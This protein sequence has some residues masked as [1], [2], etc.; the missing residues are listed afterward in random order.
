MVHSQRHLAKA[1]IFAAILALSSA[2]WGCA[3]S[4]PDIPYAELQ[5]RYA[6]PASRFL[7]LGGGLI[8]HYRDEGNPRGPVVV[9]VHGFS[10]SLHAWEGWVALLPEYRVITLDLPGHGLT[11]TP[12]NYQASIDGFSDVIETLT[13][14]LGTGPYV[15]VGNSMGGGAA[16][17]LAMRHPERLR[18]LVLVDSAGWPGARRGGPP[19]VV[20][21]IIRSGVGR[22][23]AR[24][25]DPAPLARRG[26]PSA[27]IDPALVTP[28]LVARYAE[29]AR[30]PGHREILVTINNR[31]STPVTE[32][33]F[34]A[35][36]VPTLVMHGEDDRL[37]PIA[38]GRS[39]AAA[40]PGARLVT[41]PGVGH[42]PMEQIPQRSAVDLR[43]FLESLAP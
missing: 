25:T 13:Q 12:P 9:M 42:L 27:Y 18:G 20:G 14:R 11:Q 7:D 41:Y 31:P 32:E 15:V 16:W 36:R 33:S 17:N 2:L 3:S 39:F 35:L 30:A 4:S 5:T 26:L 6:S 40:I 22:A 29:L 8:V 43:A 10:A 28:A 19:G 1:G 37:I 24:T 23:V 34:R 38:D 21:S